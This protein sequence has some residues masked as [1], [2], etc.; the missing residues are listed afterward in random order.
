MVAVLEGLQLGRE[1]VL[2]RSHAENGKEA[3]LFDGAFRLV[4]AEVEG[5]ENLLIPKPQP[6]MEGEIGELDSLYRWV[7][8]IG[9]PLQNG[10]SDGNEKN[11][12]L[13]THSDI[14]C[15]LIE[16]LHCLLALLDRAKLHDE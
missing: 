2:R 12:V 7:L 13:V 15:S 11:G 1:Q 16:F 9:L 14:L 3:V 4:V 6:E 5:Y 10:W 8:G